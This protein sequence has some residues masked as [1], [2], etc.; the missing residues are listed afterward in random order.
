[1]IF[2][3]M[4]LMLSFSAAAQI[5]Q[6]GSYTLD[7]T[8]IASGGGTSNDV[9][10]IYRVEGTIGQAVAGTSSTN[11]V[12]YSLRGGFWSPNGFAPTAAGAIVSGRVLTSDGRGITNAVMTLSGGALFSPRTVQTSGFGYFTFEDV[13]VGQAYVLTIK[14]KRF[15]FPQSSQFIVLMDNVT[16]IVFQALPEN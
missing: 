8:V 4:I 16:G 5:S 15:R 6:G 11:G 2:S 1:M 3:G 12:N 7:Q 9:G 14:S 10:N 13:E